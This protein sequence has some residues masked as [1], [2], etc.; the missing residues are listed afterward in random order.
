MAKTILITGATDG[1]GYETAQMLVAEGHHILLHGRNRKK[2]EDVESTLLQRAESDQ[3]KTFVADLSNL[4]DVRTLAQDITDQYSHLDVLINNAGVLKVDNPVTPDGLDVRFVVN[5]IAPYLLT[6]LLL[7]LMSADG[8]IINVSSAAQSSVNEE[9]LQGANIHMETME[10][11][12]QSKLAITM[13]SAHMAQTNPLGPCIIAVN[14]GSLLASKMVQEGFG[15]EG[16]DITIGAKILTQLALEEA[17]KDK[18][19]QY[20]DNDLGRFSRPHA[21][22]QNENKIQI[23]VNALE[24]LLSE[25][26]S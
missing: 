21:D 17:Y 26:F 24:K 2:L 7:P 23:V 10:A 20:F 11:Y 25:K 22:A 3:I 4:A 8:R 9:A 18:S 14:P 12:S 1:I 19:G 6:K 16:N 15:I 5:T 13:W